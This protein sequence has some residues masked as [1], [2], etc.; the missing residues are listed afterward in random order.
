MTAQQESRTIYEKFL[1]LLGIERRKPDIDA[2]RQLVF[3]YVTKIPFENVSKLYYLKSHGSRTIPNFEQFLTGIERFNFGGTCYT[4]NYYLHLLLSHLGY[5]VILCGA[6]MRNPDVHVVNIVR[7]EGREFLVDAGYAAPFTEPLPRDLK[8]DYII[9]LG[10]DRF[11]LKP[12]DDMGRSK[13][14]LRR[15]GDI[16][17][18]YTAKPIPRTI[19]H[20]TDVI[21][22]SYRSD[23][24]FMNAL[25][26]TRFFR[27]SSV[28][29]QNLIIIRSDGKEYHIENI[30]NREI[31]P[32]VIKELF[33]IPEG[34]SREAISIL[35]EFGE[36]LG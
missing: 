3:A 17:H 23:A 21:T 13:I 4:N 7:I 35:P 24:T 2:L 31:L 25:V 11:V 14:E 30:E 27:N 26:L 34:I 36:F 8:D 10:R 29:I 9:E 5:D 1:N 22:D 16:K 33:G 15:D 12:R 19:D 18:G 28:R 20:F 32:S 6:D